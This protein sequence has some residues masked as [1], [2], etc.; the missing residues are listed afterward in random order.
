MAR[1]VEVG[2]RVSEGQEIARL[3][4][5]EKQ[6]AIARAGE[7]SE[8]YKT[9]LARADDLDEQF[10]AQWIRVPNLAHRSAADGHHEEDSAEISRWGT[11][12]ERVYPVRDHKDLGE[13]LGM[14]DVE[15][16]AKVSG[17]RFGYLTG[18]AVLIEFGLVRMAL[19]ILGE[20]AGTQWDPA[21]VEKFDFV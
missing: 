11:I 2:D 1:P 17:T 20:G 15:R 10:E 14:I 19:D 13:A 5:D 18:P 3:D 16:A 9:A 8:Q 7:L 6:E 4:G 21:L 12:A